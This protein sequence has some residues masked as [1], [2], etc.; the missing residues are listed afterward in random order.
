MAKYPTN[1]VY[2][3][4]F[5][6]GAWNDS[7][8]LLLLW[9]S[10]W[11]LFV[12]VVLSQHGTTHLWEPVSCWISLYLL[13]LDN[14]PSTGF[15]W[16]SWWTPVVV[17]C[18]EVA[19]MACASSSHPASAPRQHVSRAVWSRDT[20]WHPCHPWWRERGW[21]AGWWRWAQRGLSFW[22]RFHLHD[23]FTPAFSYHFH[24]NHL[25]L[26]VCVGEVFQQWH[27]AA[28]PIIVIM[29]MPCYVTLTQRY[30]VKHLDF[31]LSLTLFPTMG[32]CR[33]SK[34]P[35]KYLEDCWKSSTILV[36]SVLNDTYWLC[37]RT[38]WAG[39]IDIILRPGTTGE[40]G[41]HFYF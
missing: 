17:P 39:Y 38:W 41:H 33:S 19:T 21:R 13:L 8:S 14:F 18:E 34:F 23:C 26:V 4:N 32:S 2:L 16:A 9:F 28:L 37:S 15:W 10:L 31:T 40:L 6:P 7:R 35:S 5:S 11:N 20:S 24:G 22:G 25:C 1:I 36:I 27:R 3:T 30:T 12:S 29:P